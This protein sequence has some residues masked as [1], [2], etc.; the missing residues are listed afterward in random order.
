MQRPK[1]GRPF[2]CFYSF[3]HSTAHPCSRYLK[4][5]TNLERQS[6]LQGVLRH[7]R[8]PGTFGRRRTWNANRP[9]SVLYGTSVF[10]VPLAGYEPGTSIGL[11]GRSVAHPR[12][13]YPWQA[14]NVE[15]QP[16]LQGVLWHIRVPGSYECHGQ[17]GFNGSMIYFCI[18]L[19]IFRTDRD[20][21]RWLQGIIKT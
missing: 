13:R 21:T 5:S 11:A 8:V 16:A 12:S 2:D 18:G 9:C 4:Q 20:L 15:R 19:G 1:G 7:I 6:A 14:P 3:P 10:Q 17:I